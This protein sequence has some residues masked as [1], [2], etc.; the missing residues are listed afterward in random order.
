VSAWDLWWV[1]VWG[2]LEAF[3]AVAAVLIILVATWRVLDW[4]RRR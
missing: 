4:W 2:L 3:L 1:I